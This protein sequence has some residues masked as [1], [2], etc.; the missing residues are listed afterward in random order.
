MAESTRANSTKMIW[1]GCKL[2]SGLLLELLEEPDAETRKA[3]EAGAFNSRLQLPPKV[4][5]S[6]MLKGANSVAN[7]FTVRGL[8]QPTFPYA[9]TP[10]PED[11]WTEWLARH[12]SMAMVT[13]GFV[14]AVPNERAAKSEAKEREPEQTGVE[15]LRPDVQNDSR[16]KTGS[17]P[18]QRV[19]AD[20]QHLRK[21]QS[22]NG[23]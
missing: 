2:P 19:E 8:A 21:L 17:L 4:R 16:M 13:R 12:K 1:V 14:F 11:F 22:L 20:A 15:P 5:Q 6:F 3:M 23:R 7:D 10:V 9:V 18:E